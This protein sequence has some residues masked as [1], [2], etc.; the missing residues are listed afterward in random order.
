MLVE[1]QVEVPFKQLESDRGF[2][3][4]VT[5]AYPAMKPYLKGFHLSLEMWRGGRDTEGW[6]LRVAAGQDCPQRNSNDPEDGHLLEDKGVVRE[7]GPASGLTPV[8]PRFRTDLEALMFL[9]TSVTPAK[10]VIRRREIITV[11]YG[12]GDASSGGFGASLDL[13]QGI[14]GRFGV[15]SR[16]EEDKSSN[17]RELRNLVDTVEEEAQAGN[18]TNSELWLFTDNSTAES[19]FTKGSSSSPLLHGLVLRLRKVEMERD[20]KLQI[21]HVA[22]TRMIAQ[23][24]DGLSRGMLCEGVLAGK[25]MLDYV[26]IAKSACQR[27]PPLREFVRSWSGAGDLRPLREEEW[28]V[29]GHG[30]VRGRKDEHGI[31]IPSHAS[32]GKVYWWDPPPVIANIALE[33]AMKAKHKRTDTYHIFTIPRLFTPAW[34]RLFHKFADFVVK[35]L[36]GSSH[37]PSGMHEPLF[38][39]ISLPFI[40]YYPWS[41]RGT[42]LLV[43]MDR[44]LRQVLESGE[45]DGGH[46]LCELLRIP[47]RISGLSEGVARGVLRMPRGGKVSDVSDHGRRR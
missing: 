12:F 4:Y 15:W 10:R 42:P 34:T 41:L 36:P 9:T 6:K 13:P 22:G 31:W 39:G 17:F 5:S 46:I 33:E 14:R 23:G 16:D 21:V 19:C 8:V 38:I 43:E 27:H 45:G 32:N 30:I 28:F 24:T 26:D 2:L 37:W 1:G 25:D 29:E 44:E 35:L 47:G 18:L 11:V 20:L 7:R 40:R 3:V